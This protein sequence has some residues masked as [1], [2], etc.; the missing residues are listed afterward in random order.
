MN[1]FVR[2][3]SVI[4]FDQTGKTFYLSI[5]YSNKKMQTILG[6]GGAIGIELAGALPKYTDKIRLVS[7]NPEKVNPGD[8]LF[9]A[10]LTSR[11]ET[12][13]A[14]KGSDV[15]Y[16]TVGLPYH[17]NVWKTT[18]PLIMRNVIDACKENKCRLVFFDNIYMYDPDYL[19]GM[20]EE[21]P[22]NPCSQKGKVRE[23]IA[24]ML[25]EKVRNGNLT[26][27][28]AR[29]ADFYGPSLKTSVL[30]ETVFK[31]LADGKK[32]I[33][34]SS[35]KYRHSYTYTPDAGTD[36]ALLGNT[37]E[38]YNQVWHLPTA[39]DPLTGKEWIEAIAKAMGVK[40]RYMVAS[41]SMVRLTG[42]FMPV[43]KE[44]VE[45]MYQYNRD[46]VFDSNKFEKKFGVKPTPYQ[47]GIEHIVRTDYK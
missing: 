10:D 24:N 44:M 36:T 26:A 16:L 4:I 9:P 17:I 20:N 43:M 38:A 12:H 25:L 42:L 41:K 27:L 23:H 7:R 33:W 28:I 45:M 32:A 34:M 2:L 18:W 40:P 22:L 37:Q 11:D 3:V 39:K 1:R 8:E 31:N 15:A 30:T 21:T 19:D 13:K 14:V 29:S 46:Y 35:V 47:K 5:C 6:S